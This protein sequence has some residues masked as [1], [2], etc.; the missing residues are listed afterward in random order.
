MPGVLAAASQ[1]ARLTGE[2]VAFPH[3]LFALPFAVIGMFLGAGAPPSAWQALW[4][5]AAMVGARTAAMSFNRIADR[6]I[7]AANPRTAMRPLPSGR[8]GT[9]WAWGVLA[10]AV[11]LFVS[12][13]AAL[14]PV[15]LMLSPVALA[16]VLGYSYTKRLTPLSHLVLGLSLA[17]APV[18]AWIAVSGPWASGAWAAPVLL[19]GAVL[20]WTAGFDIIYACQ[21][22]GFDRTHGLQ[23]I[24]ARLGVARALAV[25]SA[26]HAVMVALLVALPWALA[27]RVTLSGIYYCGVA[28]TAGV[29]VHEHRI[30]KPDDL[31][32]VNRAFFTLNGWVSIVLCT[33]TLMD[34]LM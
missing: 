19:A 24:P 15:C 30:V 23:S 21:D 6:A 12:A 32:R 16:I 7:D 33:A 20:T 17:I 8:M 2:L 4:I 28:L 13:A 9:G 29:L 34:I 11:A 31:S 5:V 10:A 22:V 18:G 14:S 1:R 3:T 27:G 25:S 26:L